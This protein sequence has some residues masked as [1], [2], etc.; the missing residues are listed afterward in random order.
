MLIYTYPIGLTS[1]TYVENNETLTLD[2][3]S[4][5]I[6]TMTINAIDYSAIDYPA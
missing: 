6:N 3:S 2:I 1:I 5:I 4:Y